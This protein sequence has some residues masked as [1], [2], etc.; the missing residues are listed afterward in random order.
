MKFPSRLGR[1][2][3]V[4]FR[5]QFDAAGAPR[6]WTATATMAS[7]PV[8]ALVARAELGEGRLFGQQSAGRR[9]VDLWTT[10]LTGDEP[11]ADSDDWDRKWRQ[12]K[13]HLRREN[14]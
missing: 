9:L 7:Q 10:N 14:S 3:T 1:V 12:R 6:R 5:R 2:T 11:S 4:L 8:A 13:T